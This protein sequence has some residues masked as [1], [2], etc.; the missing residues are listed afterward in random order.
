M[1]IVAA[2]ATPLQ[3]LPLAEGIAG[4]VACLCSAGQAD[5]FGPR[6]G[7]M[8]DDL[9]SWPA[10][11]PEVDGVWLGEGP[12]AER[13][14]TAMIG[15]RVQGG[16]AEPWA[17]PETESKWRFVAAIHDGRGRPVAAV[18]THGGPDAIVRGLDKTVRRI[19]E[20]WAL[21]L[22]PRT[23]LGRYVMRQI[24]AYTP[25]QAIR[26]LEAEGLEVLEQSANAPC[27]VRHLH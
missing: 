10:A 4:Q 21:E 8:P 2:H 27:P 11:L 5:V 14:P 23:N 13:V 19:A 24:R 3:R 15:I 16:E 9:V 7:T 18:K 22:P 26:R 17:G 25:L 12:V 6:P 1:L 20:L